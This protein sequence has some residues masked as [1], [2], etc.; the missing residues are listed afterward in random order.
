MIMD[1]KELLI[2]AIQCIL[3]VLPKKLLFLLTVFTVYE[4]FIMA[5]LRP[6]F[7]KAKSST[8]KVSSVQGK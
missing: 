2:H 1:K 5:K 8:L 3:I 7:I 6:K 4:M